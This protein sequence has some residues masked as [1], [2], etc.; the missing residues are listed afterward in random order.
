M[1]R[2]YDIFKDGMKIGAVLAINEKEA[3]REAQSKYSIKTQKE[4]T[5]K[6]A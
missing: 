6:L 1:K 5:A 2:T 4:I 3:K